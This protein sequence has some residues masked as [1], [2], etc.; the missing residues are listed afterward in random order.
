LPPTPATA[1]QEVAKIIA[2][3]N[4]ENLFDRAKAL[5]PAM[6]S[7]ASETVAAPQRLIRGPIFSLP[8]SSAQWKE[9]GRKLFLLQPA[10]TT[11]LPTPVTTT[12]GGGLSAKLVN[13]FLRTARHEASRDEYT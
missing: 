9:L 12:V 8:S 3:S 13:R 6:G 4:V 10:T 2:T 1:F 5:K 11:K 7:A